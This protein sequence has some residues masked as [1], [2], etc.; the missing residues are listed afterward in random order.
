M[1]G[2]ILSNVKMQVIGQV[3]EFLSMEGPMW[4]GLKEDT[5]PQLFG[6]MAL[7]KMGPGISC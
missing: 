1:L 7:E 4:L 6:F 2:T 5:K 3:E